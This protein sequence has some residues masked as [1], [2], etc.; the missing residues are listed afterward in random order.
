MRSPRPALFSLWAGT[1]RHEDAGSGH[2]QPLPWKN[3]VIINVERWVGA[4]HRQGYFI[5]MTGAGNYPG[6]LQVSRA[7]PEKGGVS[8]EN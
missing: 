2:G 5:I 7:A 6:S 3:H 4:A 1:R 8:A